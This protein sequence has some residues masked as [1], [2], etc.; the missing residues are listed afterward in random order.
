MRKIVDKIN[1]SH[2]GNRLV[3]CMAALATTFVIAVSVNDAMAYFTTYA[4]AEGSL[5]IKLGPRTDVR[6]GFKDWTKSIQVE[7]TGEVSVFV[8]VK[9]IAA[10]QFTITADG[11]NW[12]QGN[13]GYWYY[14]LPVEVGGMTDAIEAYIKVAE[15]VENS[16]N[17]VVVQECTP[18][19]Y[20]YD[21]NALS[22]RD[23]DWAQKAEYI[24]NTDELEEKEAE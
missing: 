1:K 23:A 16:F 14:S 10:S 11:S 6:E 9:I 20:D 8:R 3:L 7:N 4:T 5:P 22:I 24:V 21:G 12:S 18:V 17:I 15:E 2:C 13:D 19:R